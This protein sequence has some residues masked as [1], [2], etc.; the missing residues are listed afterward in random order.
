MC[1]HNVP[2][3]GADGPVFFLSYAH[4]PKVAGHG[5]TDPDF[6]AAKF[7]GD[8][9][10]H[11]VQS[12]DLPAGDGIGFMDRELRLGHQWPNRLVRALATCRVFVPLY[13]PRYFSSEHCGKE[14]SAFA[15]RADEMAAWQGENAEAIIPALWA[16]VRSDQ[17]PEAARQIQY[18]AADYGSSYAADGLY[19]LMKLS[20]HQDEYQEVVIGLATRIWEVA[21]KSPVR[22]GPVANY[23][24]LPNAFAP[25]GHTARGG[26]S[27]SRRRRRRGPATGIQ[28]GPGGQI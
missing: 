17:V 28:P 1:A 20:K 27:N 14:W 26:N 21:E 12:T 13:S 24:A 23:H 11:L 18:S 8:V 22:P 16:P 5:Q 25:R 7:F 15:R 9:C 4:A 6:Y 3:A 10:Q 19:R 2:G